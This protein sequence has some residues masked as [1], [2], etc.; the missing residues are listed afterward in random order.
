MDAEIYNYYGQQPYSDE[1]TEEEMEYYYGIEPGAEPPVD[2]MTEEEMEYY[3]GIEPG[4]EPNLETM[5]NPETY[6]G[7]EVY[8]EGTTPPDMYYD[9]FNQ[10]GQAVNTTAD[11][12]SSLVWL[13]IM[14]IVV[15]SSWKLFKKADEP[16]WAAIVPF[17]NLYV[18]LR[19]AGPWVGSGMSRIAPVRTVLLIASTICRTSMGSTVDRS[20]RGITFTG[21]LATWLATE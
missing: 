3:F 1:L 15:V 11:I 5:P 8:P 6:F 12:I 19:I 2:D 13:V 18:L 9:Y 21:S 16:G 14:V 17:Y 4:A 7:T 10:T 20:G